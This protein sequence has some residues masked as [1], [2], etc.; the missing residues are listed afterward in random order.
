MFS[1][2]AY[3]FVGKDAIEW[4]IWWSFAND[5]TSGATL[6]TEMLR[7][8][9]FHT[10]N[11]DPVTNS[12]ALSKDGVLSR[13]VMDSEEAKYVFVSIT[14]ILL[15]GHL[16]KEKLHFSPTVKKPLST[17]KL[18]QVTPQTAKN[19]EIFLQCLY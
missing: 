11:L 6:A 7:N 5:R 10:V 9:F 2:T 19:C 1:F 18:S 4:L 12:L 8:G 16:Q 3:C 15:A 17:T 14:L 13:D